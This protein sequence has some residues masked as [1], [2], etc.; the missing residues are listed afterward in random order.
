MKKRILSAAAAIAVLSTTVS[1][2][3]ISAAERIKIEAEDYTSSS[4]SLNIT[5]NAQLSNSKYVR[6]FDYPPAAGY[7]VTI[8]PNTPVLLFFC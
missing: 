4:S 8:L 3:N 1:M 5:N 7:T 6:I 2:P